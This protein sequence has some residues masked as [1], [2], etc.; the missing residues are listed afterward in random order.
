MSKTLPD[1]LR[2]RQSTASVN[3]FATQIGIP[4]PTLH[5]LLNGDRGAGVATLRKIYRAFPNDNEM[6]AAMI[7]YVFG[8][9]V[10]AAAPVAQEPQ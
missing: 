9:E 6:Q 4:V 8:E 2:A 3:A 5:A 10:A 7:A 1:L